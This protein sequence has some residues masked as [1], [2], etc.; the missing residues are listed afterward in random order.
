MVFDDLVEL[1]IEGDGIASNNLIKLVIK[2][3]GIGTSVGAR[4]QLLS[5]TDV[6]D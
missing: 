2:G 5:N 6:L 4:D 1:A 3:V